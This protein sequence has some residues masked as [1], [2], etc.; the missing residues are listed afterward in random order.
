MT[1][2]GLAEGLNIVLI[3]T[4]YLSI[5]FQG[6]K[7][8]GAEC[9]LFSTL[10]DAGGIFQVSFL[11]I[12]RWIIGARWRR[13]RFISQIYLRAVSESGRSFAWC[14]RKGIDHLACSNMAKDLLFVWFWKAI[15]FGEL[16]GLFCCRGVQ[17]MIHVV[18]CTHRFI[19]IN[20]KQGP[21]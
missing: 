3:G 11:E 21:N 6:F 7:N 12:T 1:T 13:W 17:L 15:G 8:E 2:G 14:R 9:D 16:M 19:I 5:S 18:F 20:N 4:G 10:V